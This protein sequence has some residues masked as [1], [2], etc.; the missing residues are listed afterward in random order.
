MGPA[1]A[2][3]P[4]CCRDGR[5]PLLKIWSPRLACYQRDLRVLPALAVDRR[6]QG[7]HDALVYAI[8]LIVGE[9][10]LE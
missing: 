7:T 8:D 2:T 3:A 1:P 6:Q 4:H 10:A 9:G 5:A